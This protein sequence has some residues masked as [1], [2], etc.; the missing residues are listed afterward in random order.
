VRRRG[1]TIPLTG[2]PGAE[3][4][5]S[6]VSSKG[7]QDLRAI[8]RHI[9]YLRFRDEGDHRAVGCRGESLPWQETR[10]RSGAALAG[11]LMSCR[12]R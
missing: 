8:G 12:G 6:A 9:D 5:R 11:N 10:A 7:G 2:S 3:F 4:V 1:S